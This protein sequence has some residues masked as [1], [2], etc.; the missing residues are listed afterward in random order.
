[1]KTGEKNQKT[2]VLHFFPTPQRAEAQVAKMI[3]KCGEKGYFG[4]ALVWPN[5]AYFSC[6]SLLQGSLSSLCLGIFVY[7]LLKK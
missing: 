4:A 3:R 2:H 7:S 5:H 6:F 1:M